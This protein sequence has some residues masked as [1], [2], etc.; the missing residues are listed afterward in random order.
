[1]S[2]LLIT[3]FKGG[4]GINNT[5]EKKTLRRFNH[6]GFKNLKHDVYYLPRTLVNRDLILGEDTLSKFDD[7]VSN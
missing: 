7:S 4:N 5:N 3:T 2:W 6:R 1:M